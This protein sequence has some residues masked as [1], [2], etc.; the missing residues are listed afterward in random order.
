ML[1]IKYYES[2]SGKNDVQTTYDAGTERLKAE[3]EVAI[4]YLRVRNRQDWRRPQAN[5]MSKCKEFRD[6]FEIR[7]CANN[8]QQR[9]IGYFGPDNNDFTILL[10]A[11]EKGNKLNPENWCE[12]AN[13]RRN[14]IIKGKA[15]AR[16][17]KLE[18]DPQC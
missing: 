2:S 15:R 14:E 10:W 12:K 18:G 8:L 3:L 7:F 6:F 1:T 4:T 16:Y 17:L 11:T 13:R 5:K 9:P